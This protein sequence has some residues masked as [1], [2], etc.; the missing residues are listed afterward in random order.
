MKTR[1]KT[2]WGCLGI[3]W[4]HCDTELV[5]HIFQRFRDWSR[6]QWDELHPKEY[7]FLSW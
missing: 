1:Q 7:V 3:F 6:I 4:D 5:K 2:V